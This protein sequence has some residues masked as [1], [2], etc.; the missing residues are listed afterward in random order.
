ME[1]RTDS[2]VVTLQ[3]EPIYSR[4]SA[5]NVRSFKREYDF[6]TAWRAML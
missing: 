5:D 3:N 4:G 2:L 1:L 6:F